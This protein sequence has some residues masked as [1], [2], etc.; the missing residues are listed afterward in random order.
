MPKKC[1]N[2]DSETNIRRIDTKGTHGFQ[3]HFDR[4]GNI[5]TRFFSDIGCGG[6]EQAR[7]EAR[8]FRDDLKERIPKSE[9]G[10]PAW[11]GKPRSNTGKMGVS[12]TKEMRNGREEIIVQTTVRVEKG[13]S[14][15]RKFRAYGNDLEAAIQQ[16]VEWRSA[17]IV[18]RMEREREQAQFFNE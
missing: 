8:K 18:E 14:M 11:T 16:A 7:Q 12:F 1:T 4:Q 9:T 10:S 17:V 3:V 15:N 5:Y 6:K 13:V 2:P